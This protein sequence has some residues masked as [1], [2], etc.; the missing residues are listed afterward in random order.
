M[1][2][3]QCPPDRPGQSQDRGDQA[4]REGE[5]V[6][7]DAYREMAA[8]YSAA[9]LPG[10]VTKPKDKASVENTVGERRDRGSSP[11]SAIS[12]SRRCRSCARRSVSGSTLTTRSRSRSAPGPRLT[13]VRRGGE[14]AAAA[15]AGRFRSR[16]RRGS[17]VA[18]SRRTVTWCSSGTSTPSPTTHIGRSVDLRITDTMLEVFAGD[19]RLTSHLLAPA[20][21]VNEYRTHDADLPDGPQLPAVGPGTGRGNGPRGSGR[22]PRS[23]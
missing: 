4:P 9:V 12:G 22:T 10:R 3:R 21:V 8:H 14:A 7:N 13:R 15:A 19:Q 6:L 2:R 23:S 17:T 5:V 11:R 16:S 18:R 1:V 20:G